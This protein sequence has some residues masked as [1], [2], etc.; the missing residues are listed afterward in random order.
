MW[1]KFR[2]KISSVEATE[3]TEEEI[4]A[5]GRVP[6]NEITKK[7]KK[8]ELTAKE[9]SNTIL[10][11]EYKSRFKGQGMQF[12]D[13]RVYQYGD[14]IRHI[15]WRTSAKM[16]STYVKTFEE[17][18]QL[19]LCI[20][21]DISP[22]SMFG[23]QGSNKKETAAICL[24]AFGGAAVSNQDKV[25][26]LLFDEKVVT[27]VP[28]KKGTRH[29]LR[30]IDEVIRSSSNSTTSNIDDALKLLTN[31]NKN[32]S[33]IILCSDFFSKF[34]DHYLKK[35]AKKNDVILI[36]TTDF[37]D[38]TLPNIGTLRVQDPESKEIFILPTGS[39]KYREF[40]REGQRV[41]R[42]ELSARLR[43]TGAELIH[44]STSDDPIRG[45]NN[46]FYARRKGRK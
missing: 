23:S 12:A 11:G 41:F 43:K 3:N 9:K 8:L 31:L 6:F 42:K 35:L 45:L 36:Q 21:I 2:K 19:N 20:A 40:Y 13:S 16:Q 26:L 30:I 46:F 34:D 38:E 24:A 39:S 33:M 29:L 1:W 4:R 28:P 17:D 15:D 7:V 37:R 5:S 22:S 18:K 44:I 10:S 14:D 32:G 25:S 27:Y